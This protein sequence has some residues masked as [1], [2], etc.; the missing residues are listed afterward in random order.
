[1]YPEAQDNIPL[2]LAKE[3]IDQ[4]QKQ[5]TQIGFTP[6]QARNA[7]AALSEASNLTSSLLSNQ[8]PLQ[9]CIE[10][11]VLHFPECDLPKRFLPD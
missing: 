1:M 10:Y 9:A 8:T 5:L 7:T 6:I 3:D 2:T 4:V 11:L